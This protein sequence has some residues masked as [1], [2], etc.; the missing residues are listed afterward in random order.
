[1]DTLKRGCLY[2]WIPGSSRDVTENAVLVVA[3]FYDVRLANPGIQFMQL[4]AIKKGNAATSMVIHKTQSPFGLELQN[5]GGKLSPVTDKQ[6][7][8]MLGRIPCT[9]LRNWVNRIMDQ[10]DLPRKELARLNKHV[11]K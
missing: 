9:D 2:V 4:M 3:P 8:R 1:M 7:R 5:G 6:L 11:P 10:G